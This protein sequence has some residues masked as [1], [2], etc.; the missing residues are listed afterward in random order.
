MIFVFTRIWNMDIIV[1][2]MQRPKGSNEYKDQQEIE[3]S[4]TYSTIFHTL[5]N[6]Y[7]N[8]IKHT[9]KKLFKFTLLL[10]YVLHQLNHFV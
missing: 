2:I 1:L 7:S 10:F 3:K 4:E 8:H 5:F 6:Y 9:K